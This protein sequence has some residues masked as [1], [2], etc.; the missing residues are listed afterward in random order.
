MSEFKLV[1]KENDQKCYRTG[2]PDSLL[3]DMFHYQ[4]GRNSNF[5][6]LLDKDCNIIA[7]SRSHAWQF[8]LA[9]ANHY[10]IEVRHPNTKVVLITGPVKHVVNALK[11][12]YSEFAENK[13]VLVAYPTWDKDLSHTVLCDNTVDT[14]KVLSDWFDVAE[15]V[16]EVRRSN[17]NWKELYINTEL[18][19]I[20]NIIKQND[21][22]LAMDLIRKLVEKVQK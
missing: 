9:R 4:V 1:F 16:N 17:V 21:T 14:F 15:P 19:R 12:Q 3:T 8:L 20:E 7:S 18:E 11:G 22:D 2:T 10:V 13:F 5:F 6:Q